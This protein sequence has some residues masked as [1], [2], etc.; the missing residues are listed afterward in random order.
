MKLKVGDVLDLS[1][2]D[3]PGKISSVVFFYGCNFRCPFCYN[4]KLVEGNE[5]KEKEV[6]ELIE[7]IKGKKFV[8]AVTL[9]GG[10]PTIQPEVKELCEGLKK[11]KFLVKLDTNGYEPDV[12]KK[13]IKS[14]FLDFVSMDIK[15]SP[16]KY[17]ELSGI[18]C[19]LDKIKETLEILKSSDIDYELRTT[20]VPGLNDSKEEIKKI[21]DFIKPAKVYVLQ[22][23]RPEGGTLDKSLS[24]MPKIDRKEL[25]KLAKI[26]KKEGLKV[27]TRTEEEGE[28]L[29]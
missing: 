1:T 28:E 14:G 22:Q 25:I 5:Y 13:L 3:Y 29:I 11:L 20:I 4:V 23:F 6:G 9:T 15:A 16:E 21:C 2:V 19:N 10:E 7:I 18:T 8:D 12:V 26:A 17:N 27:K 24:N